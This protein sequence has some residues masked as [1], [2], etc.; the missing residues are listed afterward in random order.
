MG[1]S[2]C[3]KTSLEGHCTAYLAGKHKLAA[4]HA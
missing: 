1:I 4:G 2:I 3:A